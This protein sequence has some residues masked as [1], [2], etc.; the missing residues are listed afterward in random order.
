MIVTCPNC[1]TKYLVDPAALGTDGRQVRCARCRHMWLQ[2]PEIRIV[3]AP[4]VAPP[5]DQTERDVRPRNLPATFEQLRRRSLRVAMGWAVLVVVVVALLTAG[6]LGRRQIVAFWPP[7]IELYDSLGIAVAN[8]GGEPIFGEGLAVEG[9]SLDRLTEDDGEVLY[10]RG[11]LINRADVTRPVPALRVRLTDADGEI[12]HEW[13]F[14]VS[15]DRLGPGESVGFETSLRNPEGTVTRL[16]IAP[17][18]EG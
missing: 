12:R 6:F 18:R 8:E 9:L 11:R 13:T 5:P 14:S 16:E 3:D 10:I 17:V 4:S 1:A 7:A 15:S 2:E